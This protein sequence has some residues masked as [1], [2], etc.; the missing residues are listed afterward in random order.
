MDAVLDRFIEE[1]NAEGVACVN[2]LGAKMAESGRT[3]EF[4]QSL[5]DVE[6]QRRLFIEFKIDTGK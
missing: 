5:T 2:K 4:I 1:G 3:D 6:L